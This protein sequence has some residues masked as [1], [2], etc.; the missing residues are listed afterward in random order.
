MPLHTVPCVLAANAAL[1][2]AISLF[3]AASSSLMVCAAALLDIATSPSAF[4]IV[5]RSSSSAPWSARPCVLE[6]M[7]E[8]S[9][10]PAGPEVINN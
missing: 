2:A 9:F 3:S 4:V 8:S 5:V 7:P 1:I 10:L 6:I